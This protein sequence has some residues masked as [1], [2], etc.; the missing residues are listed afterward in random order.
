VKF[1]VSVIAPFMVTVAGLLV[2][3]KLPIPVPVQEVN[4]CP[5]LAVA[6]IVTVL[7]A[8]RHP[9]LGVTVPP[10]DGLEAVVRRYWCG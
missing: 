5:F 2:P 7:P 3:V 6:L 4:A 10:V 8:L 9:V 1:A